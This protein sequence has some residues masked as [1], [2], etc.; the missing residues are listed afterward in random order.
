MARGSDGTHFDAEILPR[1]EDDQSPAGGT[2][3]GRP[4]PSPPIQVPRP[5]LV[6]GRVVAHY[7]GWPQPEVATREAE[8]AAWERRRPAILI[9][10][11]GE[12]NQEAG[13]SPGPSMVEL[14]D[15]RAKFWAPLIDVCSADSDDLSA[16]ARRLTHGAATPSPRCVTPHTD[17]G[18]WGWV[19][20]D[21]LSQATTA[22]LQVPQP[23]VPHLVGRGGGVVR[24]LEEKLGI[25]I[26]INDSKMGKKG[27]ATLTLCGPGPR[28]DFAKPIAMM[29]AKGMRSII[30][31]LPPPLGL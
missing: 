29:I 7:P 23:A 18:V 8:E 14:H 28:V 6:P 21:G 31:R 26:G 25:I 27:M 11:G 5:R 12:R 3:S 2:T 19:T 17:P 20:P 24:R 10:V 13:Q 22:A 4:T 15:G 1:G 9:A 30:D 16:V